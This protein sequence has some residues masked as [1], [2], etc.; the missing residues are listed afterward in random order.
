MAGSRNRRPPDPASAVRSFLSRHVLPGQRVVAGLS[1]G[2][3]SVVLLHILNEAAPRLGLRLEAMHV[4]HGL[5]PNADAWAAFCREL[6]GRWAV[7]LRIE[8]VEVGRAGGRGLEA[9]ARQA[10]HAAFGRSGA[11]WIALAHQRDDQ[12]GTLLY[13][14]LR[15]AGVRG[16]AAMPAVRAIDAHAKLMRP[17]LGVPR[18]AIEAHAH[19]HALAWIEDESNLDSR[20]SRNYLLRE[21]LIPLR[22]RFPGA[23]AA[24][25]RA[26]GHFAEAAALL[27]A[28]AE[29]DAREAAPE[30]RILLERFASLDCARARNLLRHVLS[31][32]GV[33]APDARRFDELLRQLACWRPGSGLRFAID[34]RVLRVWTGVVYVGDEATASGEPLAWRGER[35]LAWAG[36]RVR[37]TATVGEGLAAAA[38]AGERIE[39]RARNGGERLRPRAG[40]PSRSLK[41]LFQASGIAPWLRARMPLLWA[42]GALAW[43]AGVGADARFAARAGEPGVRVEWHA[44]PENP[45][46]D[47]IS[48]A[49]ARPD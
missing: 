17:L 24:L 32:E 22:E 35:E 27:D 43:V 18:A 8:R 30:G 46:R 36:G 26:A 28:I 21:V 13:N 4:H 20:F 5:S 10:R 47:P 3:D 15:G 2:V 9:A 39:L 41:A 45:A 19:R 11:D 33:R 29:Q 42:G 25:A 49:D 38:L 37:F 34:G 48:R 7:P 1:G 6:C 12:A 14:L 40:G 31:R 44:G 16:A 23:D